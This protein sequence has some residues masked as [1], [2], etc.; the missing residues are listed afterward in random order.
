[1]GGSQE[2]IEMFPKGEEITEE[3]FDDMTDAD[4]LHK[5]GDTYDLAPDLRALGEE[6]GERVAAQRWQAWVLRGRPKNPD[7]MLSMAKELFHSGILEIDRDD[8]TKYCLSP[9]LVGL[10]QQVVEVLI[11]ERW[12]AWVA[13]GRPE[14]V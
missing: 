9:D 8:P 13:L 11:E 6:E 5:T 14:R 2:V 7:R 10:P 12:E 3:L 4:I 1:M